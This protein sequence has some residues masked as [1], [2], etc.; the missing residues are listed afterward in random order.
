M[1]R[2]AALAS[3]HFRIGAGGPGA[4]ATHAMRPASTAGS[5]E[6]ILLLNSSSATRQPRISPGWLAPG[7]LCAA[8]GKEVLVVTE[9]DQSKPLVPIVA[10][11]VRIW[12]PHGHRLP[13]DRSAT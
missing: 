11:E 2:L 3:G 1:P 12:R 5:G 8:D 4:A 13:L 9:S 10:A 7:L 6:M